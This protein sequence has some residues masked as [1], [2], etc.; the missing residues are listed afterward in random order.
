[1][2]ERC[3]KCRLPLG[4][5]ERRRSYRALPSRPRLAWTCSACGLHTWGEGPVAPPA[6][7]GAQSRLL[8]DGEPDRP[9]GLAICVDKSARR[10]Q[11]VLWEEHSVRRVVTAMSLD[12]FL[13]VVEI[14]ERR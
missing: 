7:R 2:T 11:I 10:V 4:E 6:L 12:A 5:E 14:V 8:L 1:L 13:A 9:A 3:L